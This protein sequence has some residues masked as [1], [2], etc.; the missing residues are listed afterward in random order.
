V[1]RRIAVLYQDEHVVA[2]DKPP[3][4]PTSPSG[5]YWDNCLV[6]IA[7][8]LLG[9][10]KLYAVHR[11]DRETSGVNLLAK[12]E[13][14]ARLLGQEFASGDV[15]KEYSAVLKG[16]LDA[17]EIFVSVPLITDPVGTIR[18]RQVPSR[19]GR[20]AMTRFR[21]LARLERGSLVHVVPLTGR[22]HQ[23]R[24]HAWYLGHPVVGDKLYGSSD[25]EFLRSLEP[26]WRAQM[27]AQLLHASRLV[28][29]HPLHRTPVDIRS[30]P[31]RLLD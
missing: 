10:Q 5:K 12:T 2:V 24:A 6:H 14:A 28:F 23:I 8:S 4:L 1:D 15:E 17:R 7:A 31:R 22:T 9:L 13:S 3:N 19:R 21:L 27:P 20:P 16:T 25:H 29:R 26:D 18:I 30:W 11:L